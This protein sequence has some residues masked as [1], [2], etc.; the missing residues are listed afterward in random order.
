MVSFR[1]MF[2]HGTLRINN[3]RGWLELAFFPVA[4]ACP[5]HQKPSAPAELGDELLG[6]HAHFACAIHQRRR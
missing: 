1:R 5:P 2:M 6:L 3:A 4:L